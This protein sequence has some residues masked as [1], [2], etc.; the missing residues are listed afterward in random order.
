LRSEK[1]Q[2]RKACGGGSVLIGQLGGVF[3]SE[4]KKNSFP[5]RFG[6]RKV[7]FLSADFSAYVVYTTVTNNNNLYEGSS[8]HIALFSGRSSVTKVK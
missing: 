3:D 8:R 6:Y 4:K 2:K 5:S 1:S 7:N